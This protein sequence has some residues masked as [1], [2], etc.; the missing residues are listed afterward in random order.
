V[1]K[2]VL[3]EGMGWG[4]MRVMSM[5]CMEIEKCGCVMLCHVSEVGR[6]LVGIKLLVSLA[7]CVE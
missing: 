6:K 2:E 3:I 4:G 1:S 7:L 5:C